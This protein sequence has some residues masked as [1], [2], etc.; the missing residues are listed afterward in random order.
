[1]PIPADASRASAL[2]SGE[3]DLVPLLP[4]QLADGLEG[5]NGIDVVKV[6]SHK[7]V[8]IGFDVRNGIF[9]DVEFRRAVDMSIDRAAITGNLLRGLGEP[10]AQVVTQASFGYDPSLVPTAYDPEGAK[11]ALARSAYKGE[12]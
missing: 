3:V 8:Y 5:R 1:R 2:M 11:E 12:T 4:P 10:A 9:G 6:P 7:V